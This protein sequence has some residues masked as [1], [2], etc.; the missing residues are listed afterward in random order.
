[1]LPRHLSRL[2]PLPLHLCLGF[3]AVFLPDPARAET[4][5]V[6]AKESVAEETAEQSHGLELSA[7]S[8][9]GEFLAENTESSGSYAPGMTAIGGKG[10]QKL[11]EIAQS[12][13][14][15]TNKR[16]EDQQLKTMDQVMNQMTGVTRKEAW[17]KN[18]YVSRGF[19]I[20]NVRY[21]GG[22][23]ST[24]LDSSRYEDLAQ[25]DS[26][27]LLR[28]ADGLYGAGEPGGVI[29]LM[30]KR[31]MAETQVKTLT[32]AGSWDNYRGEFDVT[33]TLGLD[34]RLRGRY[35]G[36]LEDKHSFVDYDHK[37]RNL[38]YASFEFD[39]TEDTL[40]FFG[41][42]H[43]RDDLNGVR[44]TLGRYSDG[45]DLGLPRSTN[46]TTPW[47]WN[48]IE[49]TTVF[50]RLDQQLNDSWKAVAN[51]RHNINENAQNVVEL[52]N[53]IDPVTGE[54][55]VWWNNQHDFRTTE[56]TLDLN[57]QGAFELFGH[58]HDLTVGVDASKKEG[59]GGSYW[60]ELYADSVF[61]PT[62]PPYYPTAENFPDTSTDVKKV[63]SYTS[64][65]IRPM[66]DLSLIVGGRYTL[67]E[68][69][70][71]VGATGEKLSSVEEDPQ[72]V[73]YYGIVYDLTPTTSLYASHAEIYKSQATLLQGPPPGSKALEPLTGTNYEIGVKSELADGRL[74]ASFALYRIEKKG[75]GQTD[76]NYP[77]EWGAVTSC[78][79]VGNGYQL[80]EGFELELNGEVLPGLQ[81]ALGY[82]FNSNENKRDGDARFSTHT[83]RHL[84]K[85]WSDYRFQRLPALSLGAG[86]VAQSEH[87]ESGTVVPMGAGAGDSLDYSF[88]ESGYAIYSARAAY[89]LDEHWTVALN[90]NNL[91]DKTYYST[92]SSTGYGNLYGEPRS[93]L[94]SLSGRF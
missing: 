17:A 15:I 14:V 93:F 11:R 50:A 2:K 48:D 83:P 13:T 57:L 74:L 29:N 61:S 19:E 92:V 43:Q 38:N 84:F 33:G 65:R 27:G 67:K 32:S 72:F 20:T 64:L 41:V 68:D 45:S 26:V 87:S 89:D 42:S 49:S 66:D 76:P 86:V 5:E 6:A 30:Y 56:T 7:T 46:L 81:V 71:Y 36:V 62:L 18:T 10:P 1:M 9:E 82:T 55:G 75:E 69:T 22:A 34:G 58:V 40:L 54:G 3:T 12:V 79:Y 21:E 63:G 91:F 59:K 70:E 60:N 31:P 78:C 90:G 4:L 35:V 39:A 94:V 23:T 44:N 80:S 85:L 16:L 53:P 28:G 51:V 52:E 73:P 88:V 47:S 25:F 77:R 24:I 8:V 37:K